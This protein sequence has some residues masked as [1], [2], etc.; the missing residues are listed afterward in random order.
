MM[1]QKRSQQPRRAFC[2]I[3]AGLL[4][5]LALPFAASADSGKPCHWYCVHVKDHVQPR[6]DAELT[7]VEEL[8]GIYADRANSD[9]DAA[10]KV[11]YLTFDAGYENGNIARILDVLQEEDVKGTFFILRHLIDAEPELVRRMVGEG[12]T[13]GNHTAR[14]KDMSRASDEELMTELRSLEQAYEEL[15]GVTMAKLYRPPEGCFSRQNLEC[16]NENGYRTVFWSFAYPDWDNRRQMPPEKAKSI[17]LDNLH[18]GA[19]LLLHPTSS[20][21]AAILGDVIR[22]MKAQ[23]YRFAT[24]DSLAARA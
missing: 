21:N 8:G 19:V 13:V 2:A 16:L 17:I 24:V 4:F 10:E 23:G 1:F 22:E 15:T 9:P 3:L 12:H 20:T 6:A 5:A 14:H 18:N 11:A 7:F